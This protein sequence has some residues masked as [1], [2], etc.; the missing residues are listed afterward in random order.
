VTIP[1][2]PPTFVVRMRFQ[3]STGDVAFAGRSA[4]LEWGTRQHICEIDDQGDLAQRVDGTLEEGVPVDA[5]V[6]SGTLSIGNTGESGF[7]AH[8]TIPIMRTDPPPDSVPS[9]ELAA[10]EIAWRLENLGW[11]A[12][13]DRNDAV[14]RFVYSHYCTHS[15]DVRER[16]GPWTEGEHALSVQESVAHLLE[17]LLALHDGA[18]S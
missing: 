13:D 18:E 17:D 14:A 12:S 6:E 2:V 7:V 1:A 11:Y 4:R 3:T 15:G 9:M 5:D 8:V 10:R 16:Y